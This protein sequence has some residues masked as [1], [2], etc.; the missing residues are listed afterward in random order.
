MLGV[1]LKKHWHRILLL[2]L[3]VAGVGL[4]ADALWLA[5]KAKLAQILLSQAWSATL[6]DGQQHKPWPWADHWPVARLQVPDL[7]VDQIV[8]AGES[9]AVLAFAP[10]QNMQGHRPGDGGTIVI[11]GH[12]D[13]HFQFLRD[14]KNGMVINVQTREGI[15]QYQVRK[16][17]IVDSRNTKIP[18][19]GDLEQLVLVTCYPFDSLL[20]GGPLRYQVW[21][22]KAPN[23][24]WDS[25]LPMAVQAS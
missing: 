10:G 9:G 19:E 11:S 3:L 1:E 21:A 14:L 23:A 18:I 6:H 7:A 15:I 16:T 17:A 8:L 13:T 12:R 25:L 24:G 5:A 2:G 20:A 4:T 22:E